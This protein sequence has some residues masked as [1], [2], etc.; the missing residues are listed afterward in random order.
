MTEGVPGPGGRPTV[1]V[2]D[3]DALRHNYRELRRLLEPGTAMMAVVKADAYGHGDV[4]VSRVLEEE[5]CEFFG[6]ALCEEGVRLR[7]GGVRAPIVVL[8]GVYADELDALF[9]YDLTPVVFDLRMVRRIDA[10][11]ARRGVRRKVH[12]KIDSGMGRLGL[13]PGEVASFF[14]ALGGCSAVELEGVLSHLAEAESRD[15]AYTRAQLSV[16]LEAVETVKAAGCDPGLL[17]IANSAAIVASPA[18][19]LD[20]V[21]PGLMLYGAYPGEDF[22][23]KVALRPAME[24][25]SSVL[26]VKRIARGSPVG[27][28]RTF[29]AVRDT[30]VAVIPIGYGDGLL[31][32]L[33]G[34]GEVIVRGRRAPIVGLVCMD[35]TMVDVTAVE[36]VAP[37]D[38]VVI[39]GSRAGE[40]V[41]VEEVARRAGTIP[42]EV[43]CSISGRVPRLF[44]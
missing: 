5:G 23:G 19:R 25:R 12:V 39:I 34:R 1:A 32:S 35:L 44:V 42:Y 22:R 4:E 14:E 38:E 28:G 16:F 8:A 20:L 13:M 41:T 11:A 31:R 30:T 24:L 40:S 18:S 26:Q 29:T 9:D 10:A 6:V 33:S 2:I 17:H 21:R 15:G 3:R 36:G 37:G 27:Y 43:L 7:E